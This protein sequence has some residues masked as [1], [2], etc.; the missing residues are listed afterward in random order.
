MFF[1]S[2]KVEKNTSISCMLMAVERFFFSAALTAKNSPELHFHLINSFIQPSLVGSLPIPFNKLPGRLASS[3]FFHFSSFQVKAFNET[4]NETIQIVYP[5]VTDLRKD[6]HYV[7]VSSSFFTYQKNVVLP[8][9][10]YSTVKTNHQ[11]PTKYQ[12]SMTYIQ[13]Y[14][15]FLWNILTCNPSKHQQEHKKAQLLMLY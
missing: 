1:C 5:D 3:N 14:Q 2:P 9:L 11:Y 7:Q 8:K 10:S 12:K 15:V 13:H 4:Y 6:R